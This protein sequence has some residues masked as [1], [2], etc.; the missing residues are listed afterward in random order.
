VA[1]RVVMIGAGLGGTG[2]GVARQPGRMAPRRFYVLEGQVR[3]L[4][5]ALRARREQRL[6]WLDLTLTP[7]C[8]AAPAP[9]PAGA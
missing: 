2:T 1:Y 6:A 9:G 7:G 5:N 8:V 3:H 4:A